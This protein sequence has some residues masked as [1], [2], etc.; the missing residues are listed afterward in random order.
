MDPDF[1]ALAEAW[2]DNDPRLS[3]LDGD[4]KEQLVSRLAQAL[5]RRRALNQTEDGPETDLIVN[6]DRDHFR[7]DGQ[8]LTPKALDQL[9]K[10]LKERLDSPDGV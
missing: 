7:P 5:D 4:R 2:L 3:S 8:G 9:E 6:V 1:K 10:F